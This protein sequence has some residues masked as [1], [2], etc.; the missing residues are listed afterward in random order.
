MTSEERVK[1]ATATS[2][3]DDTGV[4][5]RFTG[6]SR[7]LD[8]VTSHFQA[9]RM[10]SYERY[11]DHNLFKHVRGRCRLVNQAMIK[12]FIHDKSLTSCIVDS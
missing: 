8:T 6:F 4:R 10:S 2:G 12:L 9:A 5:C 1:P 3:D 11:D 7:Y